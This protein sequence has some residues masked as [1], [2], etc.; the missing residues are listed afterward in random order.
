M[1]PG[2]NIMPNLSEF[3]ISRVHLTLILHVLTWWFDVEKGLILQ[4]RYSRL[5]LSFSCVHGV[6]S[7]WIFALL[8]GCIFC[9]VWGICICYYGV[10]YGCSGI[11]CSI[12]FIFCS[13]C[14]SIGFR[15]LSF[16]AVLSN[17]WYS[18]Y[19]W[20]T[21]LSETSVL[22]LDCIVASL[23]HWRGFEIVSSSLRFFFLA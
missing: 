22:F 15:G 18:L 3:L 12:F 9:G 5:D 11:W 17:F 20:S 7:V 13:F 23:W 16:Q 19:R 4:L 6:L 1:S 10:R 21:L 14:S 2:C 8:S